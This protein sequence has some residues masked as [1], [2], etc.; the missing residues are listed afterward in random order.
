MALGAWVS[1]CNAGGAMAMWP[2]DVSE[3]DGAHIPDRSHPLCE[4]SGGNFAHHVGNVIISPS[5]GGG[6]GNGS[7]I[8]GLDW[9]RRIR[10]SSRIGLSSRCIIILPG[11]SLSC[12]YRNTKSIFF[13]IAFNKRILH[14]TIADQPLSCCERYITII[15]GLRLQSCNCPAYVCRSGP[16]S[17]TD[18]VRAI[19]KVM[20]EVNA[21]PGS[22]RITLVFCISLRQQ[23][24]GR[25]F[26]WLCLW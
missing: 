15:S 25:V 8:R 9:K 26:I 22:G 6:R 17:A 2:A 1:T 5:W 10:V 11:L 20:T 19:G 13:N 3:V 16:Q 12:A 24:P 18:G 23:M 7:T 21:S 14:H 4:M